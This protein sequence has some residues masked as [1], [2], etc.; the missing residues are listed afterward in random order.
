MTGWVKIHR[1]ILSDEWEWYGDANTTYLFMCLVI[2][3]NHQP[4]NWRGETIDRGQILTG[5]KQLSEKL[6]ISE[7]NIR[8]SLDKLKS[9]NKITIKSTNK[10]SVI[11][12]KNYDLYQQSTNN[13]TNN[14]PTTN[15]QLTTSKNIKNDKNEKKY[16]PIY[17]LNDS[18]FEDISQKYNV[19][20]AFVR[21]QYDSMVNWH[22][23]TGK[24]RKDWIA[25]LRGFV[26]RDA[27]KIRKEHND[28]SKIV[29]IS[30]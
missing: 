29:S 3:A 1:D 14:Q 17:D 13:P 22:E 21:S 30:D 25:T 16:I 8:T 24:R 9:T 26:K 7:Q 15:Q 5:R 12:I 4:T 11:S 28:R 27:I 18:H 10:Y 2:L 6:G 20:I 23:S 19:P